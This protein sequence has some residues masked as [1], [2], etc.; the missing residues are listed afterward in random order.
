MKTVKTSI[1]LFKTYY[2]I[3]QV[4]ILSILI[5]G[6]IIPKTISAPSD[7]LVALG[8]VTIILYPIYLYYI[9]KVFWDIYNKWK[10]KGDSENG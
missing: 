5:V 2:Y 1:L 8:V 6:Y 4:I 3:V 9:G 7:I 10:E